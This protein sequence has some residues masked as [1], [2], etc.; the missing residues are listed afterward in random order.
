METLSELNVRQ[1]TLSQNEKVFLDE[2]G[3][4]NL[5]PLLSSQQVQKINDR[6]RSLMTLEGDQAGSELMDSPYI[7]HPKEAG[8]DRLADLILMPGT[9]AR[10]I[11]RIKSEG[12]FTVISADRISLNKLTSHAI[13]SMKL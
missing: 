6:I 10:T 13:S 3:Y 11:K 2:N 7:R 1:D 5:G 12:P 8:A 4:L 9:E